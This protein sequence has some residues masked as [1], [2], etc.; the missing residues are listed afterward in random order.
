VLRRATVWLL[1]VLG[2]LALV[3]YLGGG[4]YFAGEIHATG[5]QVRAA[6]D[7]RTLRVA[8]AGEG[9]VTLTETANEVS[10]L[11]DPAT[12]GLVYRDGYGHVSGRPRVASGPAGAEAVSRRLRV[13]HG[14]RPQVGD[15]AD[16]QRDAFPAAHPAVAVGRPVRQV[17]YRAPLGDFPAWLVPGRS[18][19]WAIFTHGAIGA[20]RAEALRAMRTTVA[21]GLPTLA[22]TY[23]NDP[24]A[25]ADGSGMWRYGATEWRDLEGAVRFAVEQGADDVV[26]VGYSMG[27]AITASFLRH[28]PLAERVSRVVF[29]APMLDF[30]ETVDY[31]ASQRSLPVLGE[32][33]QSL[34][35]VARQIAALRYGVDWDSVDYLDDT[36]WLRVPALVFHGEEDPRVPL[37]LSR[38]FEDDHPDLVTLEVVPG[39]GHV[40]A[41]N[42]GPRAYDR[43]LRRF[44]R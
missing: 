42:F 24:G 26:L 16:L 41:W 5:L 1:V 7:D 32:V 31:G 18:S 14:A 28:S 25:P 35:W 21:L 20:T 36:S 8:R 43:A 29:D 44:L 15:M 11:R 23:R 33:P 38:S 22:I 13:V 6:D 37:H 39:A 27:G 2:V 3:F 34:A 4:W 40:E 30:A 19:T 10:A 12:Y 17:R 9:T